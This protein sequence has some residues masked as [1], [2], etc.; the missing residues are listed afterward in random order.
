MKLTIKPEKVIVKPAQYRVEFFESREY[1]D[2]VGG[3]GGYETMND[4]RPDIAAWLDAN[5]PEWTA[6]FDRGDWGEGPAVVKI[7]FK[8]ESHAKMFHEQWNSIPC[9]NVSSRLHCSHLNNAIRSA[10][11][12]DERQSKCE[13]C[14]HEIKIY[15]GNE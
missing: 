7:D 4:F 9:P 1:S 15:K 12:S 11:S 13:T 8:E 6:D 14:G 3:N 10:N 2:Y 5:T